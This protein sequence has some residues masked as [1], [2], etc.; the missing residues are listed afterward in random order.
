MFIDSNASQ[1]PIPTP[2]GFEILLFTE[3]EGARTEILR[4]ADGVYVVRDIVI[5]VAEDGEEIDPADLVFEGLSSKR[6]LGEGNAE[7]AA[8]AFVANSLALEAAA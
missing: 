4:D 6:Y 1:G 2:P 5:E 8:A 7:R 3:V